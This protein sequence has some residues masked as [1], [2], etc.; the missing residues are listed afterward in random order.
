MPE[1]PESEEEGELRTL[2]QLVLD[3]GEVYFKLPF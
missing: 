3:I 2:T 1:V